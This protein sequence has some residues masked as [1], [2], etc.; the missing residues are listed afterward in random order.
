VVV[1]SVCVLAAGVGAARVL[2][3]FA[4]GAPVRPIDRDRDDY[5]LLATADLNLKSGNGQLV[6]VTGGD[7][8]VDTPG[9]TLHLCGGGSPH[10]LEAGDGTQIN[11]D[12]AEIGAACSVYDV[13]TNNLVGTPTIRNSGPDPLTFVTVNGGEHLVSN[14][15]TLPSFGDPCGAPDHTGG[16]TLAPGVHGD[17]RLQGQTLTLQAGTY[18]CCSLTGGGGTIVGDPAG[19]TVQVWEDVQ[20]GNGASVGPC[21]MTWYIAN[22]G[23]GAGADQSS[24]GRNSTIAGHFYAMNGDLA[25]GHSSHLFGNFYAN[26]IG[27]DF[28]TEVTAC[29]DG[30]TTTTSTSTSTTTTTAPS[31]TTSTSTSTST[32][33]TTAP[34]TTTSTSTSTSTTTT[35]TSTSTSTT[36]TTAPATTTSTSA[37]TSTTVAGT[38]STSATTS[39]TVAGTT[40]TSATTSTTVA[41]TTTIVT[42][43]TTST[44]IPRTVTTG[45]DHVTPTT[46][47][48]SLPRTGSDG[49]PPLLGLVA[50]VV[51]GALALVSRRR[52]PHAS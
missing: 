18:S 33:T 27:S 20:F 40:S 8:G 28:N 14:P 9:G 7:V 38:T 51:G 25:L 46:A 11:A 13:F 16:G 34:S 10:P 12:N 44:T 30:T 22:N 37:T 23:T 48:R 50:L 24:F 45:G 29:Q 32:T 42:L 2:P 36:T 17:V 4:A 5:V 31:T 3:A 52:A 15:P 43:G 1:A 35:S 47:G 49:R 19:T 6:K 39:T 26:R 21:S 41:D